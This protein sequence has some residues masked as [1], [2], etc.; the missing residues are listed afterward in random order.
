MKLSRRPFIVAI[1]VLLVAATGYAYW[2]YQ[3]REGADGYITEDVVRGRIAATV[4]ATGVVNPV[5]SVQVGTYVS[6]PIKAIYAD[7]N[8]KVTKGQIVAKIDPASYQVKVRSSE[9]AVAN[10]KAKLAKDRADLVLKQLTL[11][12]NRQLLDKKFV[13]QNDVDMAKSN[14][15]QAVAQLAL[16]QAAIQQAEADLE[17]AR[18]N[19]SY[20]D[21]SSPVDG[22]VVSRSVDV[23]QT[24]AAS[25]QTPTLFLIAKDLTKMQV[26]ANVSES[27]IGGVQIGQTVTFHVDAYPGKDFQGKIVQVRMAPTTV[28][29][30]VTYDVVVGVDNPNLELRPGMTA[31]VT[32]TTAERDDVLKVSLRALRFRPERSDAAPTPRA[33]GKS[34]QPSRE[35]GPSVW[36]VEPDGR[37]RRMKIQAGVRDDRF[38]EVVSGDLKEGD[39]LAVAYKRPETDTTATAQRPPPFAGGGGGGGARRAFR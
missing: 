16:D 31:T 30:V 15:D 9:A 25:F 10:A 34:Q 18:I 24:V 14:Y 5:T 38:A 29:N 32:I 33:D 27:D 17:A 6:G 37:L 3:A 21:I 36:V 39:V 2:R 7:Y 35:H 22:V 28:Q 20:T 4:T 1:A 12:R 23:G 19:L 13:S 11:E 8:S 26:D